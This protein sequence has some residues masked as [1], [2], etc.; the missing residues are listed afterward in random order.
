ML[1][2]FDNR[3]IS[4]TDDTD[5]RELVV[6]LVGRHFDFLVAN[7]H[8]PRFMVTN[9]ANSE[10]VSSFFSAP[11]MRTNLHVF[12]TLLQRGNVQIPPLT[13][14]QD[15]LS[16]N[17]SAFLL[18]PVI[19]QFGGGSQTYLSQRCQENMELIR[20]RLNC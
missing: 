1:G 3:I 8:L 18:L 4:S 10:L 15:I 17:V 13:L 20:A 7:P 16:L 9:M 2:I 12:A 14:V 5:V 11:F 6:G 19:E